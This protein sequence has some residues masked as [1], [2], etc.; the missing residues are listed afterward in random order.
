M[1]RSRPEWNLRILT[2]ASSTSGRWPRSVLGHDIPR[3]ADGQAYTPAMEP[4]SSSVTVGLLG[5]WRRGS[6]RTAKLL[7]EPTESKCREPR[8]VWQQYGWWR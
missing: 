6:E 4:I 1:L 5:L 3:A 2:Y 8:T 7:Q